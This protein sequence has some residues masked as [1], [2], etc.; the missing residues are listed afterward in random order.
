MI[1]W[2]CFIAAAG[3]F[4][5]GTAVRAQTLTLER[6]VVDFGLVYDNESIAARVK[7]TNTGNAQLKIDKVNTTCGCT[8]G[9]LQKRQL[10]PNESTVATLTFDPTGKNGEESKVV[11]F[12]TN[13]PVQANHTVTVMAQVIPLW[14]LDPTKLQFVFRTK[15]AGFKQESLFFRIINNSEEELTVLSVDS[16]EPNIRIENNKPVVISPGETQQ[17]TATARDG[18]EPDS[19]SSSKVMI[20]GRIDDKEQVKKLG[21]RVKVE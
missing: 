4:I 16:R 18:W 8:V 19:R 5:T 7:I 10:E 14:E 13:D 1:R 11:T 12:V 17:Y 2:I 9:R 6:S 21:L 15:A 3:L 20:V